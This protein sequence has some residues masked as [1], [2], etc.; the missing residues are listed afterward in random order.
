MAGVS[1]VDSNPNVTGFDPPPPTYAA[2]EPYYPFLLLGVLTQ[3]RVTCA[4]APNDPNGHKRFWRPGVA[5]GG[6]EVQN[7]VA[8][9]ILDSTGESTRVFDKSS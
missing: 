7:K 2:S 6:S 5:G 1:G 4:I 3:S 8:V 9:Y